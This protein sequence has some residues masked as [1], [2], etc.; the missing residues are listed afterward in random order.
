M[1]DK[2]NGS[3]KCDLLR[4][5]MQLKNICHNVSKFLVSWRGMDIFEKKF[6]KKVNP[7]P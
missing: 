6:L 1:Q 2:R 4:A 5:T 3:E 7:E